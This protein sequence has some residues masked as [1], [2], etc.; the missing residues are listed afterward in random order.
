MHNKIF[1]CS[2][3][4]ELTGGAPRAIIPDEF[5]IESITICSNNFN[6]DI[7]ALHAANNGIA[8]V[9]RDAEL[10]LYSATEKME[11]NSYFY[12]PKDDRARPTPNERE[13]ALLDAVEITPAPDISIAL[14][15][16]FDPLGDWVMSR[17]SVESE[18]FSVVSKILANTNS[19]LVQQCLDTV[20]VDQIPQ[21]AQA[22]HFYFH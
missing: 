12:P 8:G 22:E 19:Y 17:W 6:S 14:T 18:H 9:L 11:F 20:A 7:E 1:E 16:Q 3:I 15:K 13:L 2:Y 10:Q 4:L 5:G 21:V